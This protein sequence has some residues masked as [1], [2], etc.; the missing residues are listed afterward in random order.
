MAKTISTE[1]GKWYRVTYRQAGTRRK[2]HVAIR[3]GVAA[4]AIDGMDVVGAVEVADP[5]RQ[6]G[7]V[8][9]PACGHHGSHC[10]EDLDN[11]TTICHSTGL[12]VAL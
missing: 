5:K 1:A 11:G 2:V 9:C 8:D 4:G 7:R 10:Q 12:A 6:D 3:F